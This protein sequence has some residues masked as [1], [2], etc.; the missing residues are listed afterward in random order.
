MQSICGVEMMICVIQLVQEGVSSHL[1]GD[2][3]L[4]MRQMENV[5]LMWMEALLLLL[6]Q[7]LFTVVLITLMESITIQEIVLQEM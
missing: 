2:T 7:Q 6:A 1:I 5:D 3:A 4:V